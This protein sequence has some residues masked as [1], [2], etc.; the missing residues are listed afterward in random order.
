MIQNIR[1]AAWI[2]T[3]IFFL[4]CS[5]TSKKQKDSVVTEKK[6]ELA[7]LKTDKTKIDDKIK[8]LESELEK[9]D[10]GAARAIKAKLVGVQPVIL[11]SF[12][13]Y[14]DLQGKIDAENIS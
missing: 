11:Q 2:I 13:H 3:T 7:K 8:S 9:I 14:L 5:N 10:T 1:Q 6:T 4:S 12:S